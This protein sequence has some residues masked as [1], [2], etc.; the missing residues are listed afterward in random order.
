MSIVSVL[1]SLLQ[2]TTFATSDCFTFF[3]STELLFII[4][5]GSVVTLD[6]PKYFHSCDFIWPPLLSV[7]QADR[8]G[9]ITPIPQIKK[10]RE[11]FFF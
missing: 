10:L 6:I 2:C 8:E 4:N 7:K 1:K 5:V 9:I 11:Q 3:F